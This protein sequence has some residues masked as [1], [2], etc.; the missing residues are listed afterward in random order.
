VDAVWGGIAMSESLV[1]THI[2]DLRRVLG[3]DVIETVAARGYRFLTDVTEINDACNGKGLAGE[4]PL[5]LVRTYES[6]SSGQAGE[7]AQAVRPVDVAR[8]LKELSDALATLGM[9]ATVL[10]LVGDE[11]SE[12]MAEPAGDDGEKPSLPPGRLTA[13]N[14][15]G[16]RPLREAQP[17]IALRLLVPALAS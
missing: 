12:R 4:G 16:D 9:K 15:A 2:R 3:E 5:E 13:G 6:S 10:L 14:R 17:A 1:R 11:Q 7:V 8:I